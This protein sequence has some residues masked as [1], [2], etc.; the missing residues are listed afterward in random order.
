MLFAAALTSGCAVSGGC[1]WEP[2]CGI[3]SPRHHLTWR[4]LG[5]RPSLLCR[6]PCR[7]PIS[8]LCVLHRPSTPIRLM[9]CPAG[10]ATAAASP[11]G[12][13]G[14]PPA[15]CAGV[16]AGR[17]AVTECRRLMFPSTGPTLVDHACGMS[18]LCACLPATA[19]HKMS[20]PVP[21]AD[22]CGSPMSVPCAC[23]SAAARLNPLNPG[24]TRRAPLRL[25]ATP[26]AQC[27]RCHDDT[28]GRH[29]HVCAPSTCSLRM[30]HPKPGAEEFCLGCGLCRAEQ[31]GHS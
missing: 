15:W 19:H 25:H 27:N 1:G 30:P 13:A 6:R 24:P 5:K 28:S 29:A 31:Q 23:L 20:W 4:H 18:L 17:V 8:Y 21:R 10:A 26:L 14:A 12:T 3:S 16:R 22:A 7:P 11:A 9:A 2:G